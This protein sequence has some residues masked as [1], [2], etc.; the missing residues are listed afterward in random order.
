MTT[1]SACDGCLEKNSS[2]C[3]ICLYPIRTMEEI[4][5]IFKKREKMGIAPNDHMDTLNKKKYEAYIIKREE[6]I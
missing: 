5:K 6:L 4:I 2:K 3:E 1:V